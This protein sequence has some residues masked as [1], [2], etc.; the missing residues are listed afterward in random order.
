MG[1]KP[2]LNSRSLAIMSPAWPLPGMHAAARRPGLGARAA[3]RRCTH[4]CECMLAHACPRARAQACARAWVTGQRPSRTE[5]SD[6]V[7]HTR[8]RAHTH[9]LPRDNTHA[10]VP[11]KIT[12]AQLPVQC[13]RRAAG[14][15]DHAARPIVRLR[16]P[17]PGLASVNAGLC[18]GQHR[19]LHGPTPGFSIAMLCRRS[20][21]FVRV[22]LAP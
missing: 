8:A 13:A 17:T 16:P 22:R 14:A 21:C 6:A 15:R 20:S 11:T 12:R 3:A 10:R 19:A 18:L 2:K 1:G 5:R 7:R 9:T 4:A